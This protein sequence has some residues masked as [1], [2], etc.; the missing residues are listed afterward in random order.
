MVET[1]EEVSEEA[2][3][4]VWRV[5][6]F[7]ALTACLLWRNSEDRILKLCSTFGPFLQLVRVALD[8][9]IGGC[10]SV[11]LFIAERKVNASRWMTSRRPN[12]PVRNRTFESALL[13]STFTRRHN[14]L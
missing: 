13:K 7:C 10:C 5:E 8:C 6:D 14:L 1:G 3:E 11:K 2:V 9:D 4:K 12:S